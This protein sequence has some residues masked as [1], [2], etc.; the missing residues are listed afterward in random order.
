MS[1]SNVVIDYLE[2]LPQHEKDALSLLRNQILKLVPDMEERLCRGV[3]FF[4]YKG[5]R[6]VGIRASKKHLS[7][8]IMEGNVL[9]DLQKEIAHLDY[10]NT[11]IR[12]KAERSIS[13]N[14]VK[15]LVLARVKEIDE[16][17][18]R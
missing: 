7:F 3:P 2:K 17:L 14:L 1:E 15:R 5:K 9:K 16:Y 12:F 8:F 18:N 10:S 6:A 4:Y 13:S 11:V